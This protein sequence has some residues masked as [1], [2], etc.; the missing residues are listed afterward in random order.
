MESSEINPQGLPSDFYSPARIGIW[1][2]AS[3][4]DDIGIEVVTGTLGYCV[5]EIPAIPDLSSPRF[6]D[7]AKLDKAQRVGR[8]GERMNQFLAAL[9]TLEVFSAVSL[10][11][12][13]QPQ[14]DGGRVRLFLIG[15]SC[16]DDS[17]QAIEGINRFREIVQRNFPNEYRLDYLERSKNEELFQKIL[18]LEGVRSIAELLKP[19]DVPRAWHKPEHCGFSFYYVSRFFE[20]SAN[21]MVEFCRSLMRDS[22]GREAVVDICLVP[23]KPI[24]DAERAH[25]NRWKLTC[26]QWARSFEQTVGGGLYSEPVRYK[27]EADP[28]AQEAKK[29]YDELLQRYGS[30]QH[31]YFLYSIRALSWDSNPPTA[32]LNSLSSYALAAA[33]NPQ[34]KE[35]GENHPT[36]LRAL[37]AARFCS[38][39]PAVC[40]DDIWQLE[41]SPETIRRL[42]RIA[43]L[44]EISGFFRFPTAGRDGCPGF[45]SDEGIV[46]TK[47]EKP[48]TAPTNLMREIWL[49]NYSEDGRILPKAA[50]VKVDDLVKHLLVVGMP[51]SGKTTLCFS[52]LQQLWDKYKIPF[53]VLEPAKT[54]YRGLKK[55]PCFRD[56]LLVFTVGNEMLS[57]F[58]FNPFEVPRGVPLLEHL[59]T[60]R[61]CFSG[62]FDLF[63][64]LPMILEKALSDMYFDKGWSKYGDNEN[65]EPPTMQDLLHKVVEHTENAGYKGEAAANIRAALELRI[66]SLTQDAKGECLNTRHSIPFEILMQKPVILELDA[67]NADEKAL[68][69]MFI[70]S[71]VRATA[72][73]HQ[74][75]RK[76]TLS[77]LVLVEEAH[78]LIGRNDGKGSADRANP[79][80]VAIRFFT[81]MLAEMRAWGEG[82]IIS[83]QL[84]TA[85]AAE[86][87]K[88]TKIK[89]MHKLN[90]IEDTRFMG[91]TM[92][93]NDA[94]FQQVL[95]LPTGQS[96]FFTGDESRSRLIV[97]PNF[98][99]NCED[100]G[101]EIEPPPFDWE[102]AEQMKSFR[103]Q[104]SEIFLPYSQC[105][106]ICRFCDLRLREEIER[107]ADKKLSV[108]KEKIAER[109]KLGKVSAEFVAVAEMLE[110]VK[111]DKN[112]S[113]RNGCVMVHYTEKILPRLTI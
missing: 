75:E 59:S 39:S 62:A 10:R 96:L 45:E 106:N 77:H 89:V 20:P 21:D 14:A 22:H 52:L 5:F 17:R 16:G 98:K 36:F 105:F 4:P 3:F 8:M 15:R 111:E 74:R 43:D 82:I 66:A 12:Y 57:P 95:S 83:D 33:N 78:N 99:K 58:R 69:M 88:Q 41:E 60:L 108:I 109:K 104:V 55:L 30:A 53:I 35:I 7:Y 11:Y 68:M 67:F 31:S 80:E 9:H 103:E 34:I 44:K 84:P 25:L 38:V 42:H 18:D 72:K 19:E 63:G 6:P 64:P 70:L 2:G 85:I 86:A 24:T 94:Q 76:E 102:I 81:G 87:V 37:K 28:N 49:G 107:F 48:L 1:N 23:T 61:T 100:E 29:V 13:F 51:G 27:F 101:I 71:L 50:N 40:R 92:N 113:V 56:D 54:E 110:A 90:S 93:L 26:D 46:K 97:E 73:V 65:L 79:Q 112:N 91:D 47:K 32:I